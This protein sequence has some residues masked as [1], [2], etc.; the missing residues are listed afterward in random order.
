MGIIRN[1]LIATLV[2]AS[3][4]FVAIWYYYYDPT[5][6]EVTDENDTL[7]R[8]HGYSFPSIYTLITLWTVAALVMLALVPGM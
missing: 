8:D 7:L 5:F 6:H 2:L 3:G 4:I 1:W